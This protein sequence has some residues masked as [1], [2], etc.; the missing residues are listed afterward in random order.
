MTP[1]GTATLSSF[2]GLS[3]FSPG[4][5]ATSIVALSSGLPS[6]SPLTAYLHSTHLGAQA[7][8]AWPPQPTLL[9][10]AGLPL[11]LAH[12][13][14]FSV[15]TRDTPESSQARG[16]TWLRNVQL[17]RVKAKLTVRACNPRAQA[18]RQ[19]DHKWPTT[20]DPILKRQSKARTLIH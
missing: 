13:R 19:E 16:H 6:V 18:M 15:G 17:K 4:Q 9:P 3:F 20:G 1:L 14:S 10:Q 11:P 7:Q 5:G 2:L 8:A 12:L